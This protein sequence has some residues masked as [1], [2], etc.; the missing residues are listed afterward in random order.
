[1]NTNEGEKSD[2]RCQR[3]DAKFGIKSGFIKMGQLLLWTQQE[4][5]EVPI[6]DTRKWQK[7]AVVLW[8]EV[9]FH[10]C[11]THAFLPLHRQKK[12]TFGL[13][14]YYR[15]KIGLKKKYNRDDSTKKKLISK[16]SLSFFC[17]KGWEATFYFHPIYCCYYNVVSL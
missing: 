12:A 4:K 11:N 7:R 17:A 6:F 16:H 2:G 3:S 15:S 14:I 9:F 8:Q 10:L 13:T 1:M 5:R